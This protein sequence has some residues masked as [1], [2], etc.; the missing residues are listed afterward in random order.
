MIPHKRQARQTFCSHFS[1]LSLSSFFSL[2]RPNLPNPGRL[3]F[4]RTGRPEITGSHR[5]KWKGQGRSARL[6]TQ[7]LRGIHTR[8][9]VN[10]MADLATKLSNIP[11]TFLRDFLSPK[12]E[13]ILFLNDLEEE[14]VFFSV[15]CTF[16]R[17]KLAKIAGYFELTVPR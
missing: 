11:P 15:I 16:S 3:P 10:N 4:V 14:F 2:L 13:D 9:D 7:S 12:E 17:R 1:S 5:R 8:A 6:L